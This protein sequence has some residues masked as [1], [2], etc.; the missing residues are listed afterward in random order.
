MKHRAGSENVSDL[1]TKCL[2]SQ[3]FFKH[4]ETLGFEER[5]MPDLS[6][7]SCYIDR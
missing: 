3:L 4:H 1:F 7:G 2:S 5:S 6:E